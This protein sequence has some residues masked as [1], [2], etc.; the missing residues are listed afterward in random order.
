MAQHGRTCMRPTPHLIV[1]IHPPPDLAKTQSKPLGAFARDPAHCLPAH[2]LHH[3]RCVWRQLPCHA[4]CGRRLAPD[5]PF[6]GSG[7]PPLTSLLSSALHV[8]PELFCREHPARRPLPAP[9]ARLRARLRGA[10]A[11]GII[12]TRITRISNSILNCEIREM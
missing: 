9:S 6:A 2:P 10:C 1:I 3:R 4:P 12:I 7:H 5:S 8:A 11:R